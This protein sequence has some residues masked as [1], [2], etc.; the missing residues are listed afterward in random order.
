MFRKTLI[1][2]ALSGALAFTGAAPA[3]AEPGGQDYARVLFGLLALGAIANAVEDRRE[4]R[5]NKAVPAHGTYDPEPYWRDQDRRGGRRDR[6]RV[7]PARC[8]FAVRTRGGWADVLSKRCLE[9][10]GVRVNR[11]P[12]RCEFRVRTDR[13]RRSVFGSDCLE[14]YGYTVEARWRRDHR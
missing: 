10:E 14:R 7:L 11:L 8:E 2:T 1:A 3:F 13:G 6:W 5:E 12:E 4:D 9:R